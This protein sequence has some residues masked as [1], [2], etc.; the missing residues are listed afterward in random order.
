LPRGYAW[1]IRVALLLF[2]IV[3]G[4]ALYAGLG[5]RQFTLYAVGGKDALAIVGLSFGIYA[6]IQIVLRYIAVPNP[7]IK[8]ANRQPARLG[9]PEAQAVPANATQES[10]Q[11]IEYINLKRQFAVHQLE[12]WNHDVIWFLRPLIQRVA[13]E[14]CTIRFR[15]TR[16]DGEQDE[17]MLRGE[18]LFGRWNDNREPVSRMGFELGTAAVNRR[19]AKLFPTE[20]AGNIDAYP[21]TV[22]FAIK[23]EGEEEFFHFNDESYAWGFGWRNPEWQLGIGIYRVDVRLTGYG[24]LR[25]T[26]QTFR[27]I[28]KGKAFDEFI[29]EEW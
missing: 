22:A 20:K 26:T 29:L 5:L 6:T 14:G 28:N 19:L 21:F 10:R 16:T 12:V 23:K 13:M 17:P 15:Y 1:F 9:P 24:L 18:W 3:G 25:A 27:V 2:C 8:I 7:I 11:A 4:W